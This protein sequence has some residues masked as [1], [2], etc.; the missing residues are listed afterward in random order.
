MY[1]ISS[2]KKLKY[3]KYHKTANKNAKKILHQL[4]SVRIQ[5]RNFYAIQSFMSPRKYPITPTS[6]SITNISG[7]MSSKWC[8][9]RLSKNAKN[10]EFLDRISL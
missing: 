9:V 7:N 2:K 6:E 3:H 4:V 8:H 10:H 1:N 5:K